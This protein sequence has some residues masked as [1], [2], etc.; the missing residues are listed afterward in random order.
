MLD[1]QLLRSHIETVAA[2]LASRGLTLDA[3]T[4]AALEDGRKSL[5]TRTQ[6]LQAKRNALSKQI[7]MLK[8]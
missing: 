3:T 6:E 2:R 4:F 5:Q 8:G 7:G 1:V